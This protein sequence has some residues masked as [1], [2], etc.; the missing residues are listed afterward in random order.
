MA[1]DPEAARHACAVS[2]GAVARGR[3]AR[4]VLE[5]ADGLAYLHA[6]HVAHRDLKPANVLLRGDDSVAIADFGVAHRF[7]GGLGGS[8]GAT[9]SAA[10]DA[11]L[12]GAAK[13]ARLRRLE[14]AASLAQI[15]GTEGTYAYW[16]P[17]MVA[18]AAAGEKVH[19]NAFAC[20]AWALGCCYYNFRTRRNPF[21]VADSVEGL[22]DAIRA[23]V[24][25]LSDAALG[26]EERR[27]LAA[28]LARD[29]AARAT[30]ADLLEDP[31]LR[32]AQREDT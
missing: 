32:A 21:D 18:T 29:A 28:L 10:A 27:V 31:W 1:Y 2:G 8:E 7:A 23:G 14:R 19:F 24:V 16:A 6:R 4:Y 25:D 15:S 12:E 9:D 3:A 5:L 26:A 20:D 30:M 17:E 11:R 22:F 13:L